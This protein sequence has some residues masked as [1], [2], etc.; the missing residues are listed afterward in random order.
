MI[1]HLMTKAG[2]GCSAFLG[3]ISRNFNS[4]MVLDATSEWMVTE[5]DEFDRSFLQLFPWAAVV[6]AMDPD[7]LTFTAMCV[8]CTLPL[9]SLW[10]RLIQGHI[11]DE[12]RP[13]DPQICHA[14]TCI[15]VFHFRE[16]VISAPGTSD[17]ITGYIIL[18]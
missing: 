15:Y 6:T 8:K 16:Q 7:H 3:G 14:R 10:H 9:I 18:I 5:A 13:S 11:A 12:V 1:A 4:N 2:P 17:C